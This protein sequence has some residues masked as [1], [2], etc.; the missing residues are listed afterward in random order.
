[1]DCVQCFFHGAVLT[2]RQYPMALG[3]RDQNN[4]AGGAL[5]RNARSRAGESAADFFQRT[6]PAAEPVPQRR[7]CI[8]RFHKRGYG[9][10]GGGQCFAARQFLGCGVGRSPCCF[11]FIH[12]LSGARV[13][14]SA[15]RCRSRGATHAYSG[16]QAPFSLSSPAILSRCHSRA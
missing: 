12:C 6:A 7:R 13:P 4:G 3:W 11:F 9:R 5:I 10:A 8:P 2:A 14:P 15:A 16:E 1:M